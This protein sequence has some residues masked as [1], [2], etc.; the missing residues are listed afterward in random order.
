[1]L[2]Q[3]IA[4]GGQTRNAFREAKATLLGDY[5]DPAEALALFDSLIADKPG[6]PSLLNGKC[7]TKGTRAVMLDSALKDCTQAIEL[8]SE[9]SSELDSRALV[10]YRLGKYDQALADLDAVIA[11]SPGVAESRFMR[12]IVLKQLHRDADAARELAVARRLSPN[13]DRTY[14]RYGIKAS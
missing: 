1:M 12:S 14:A 6:S 8:S 9:T 5:G 2:D 10:W 11:T 3:R 4:L 13:V 7:W